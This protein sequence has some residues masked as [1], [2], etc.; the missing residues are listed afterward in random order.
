LSVVA[1]TGVYVEPFKNIG[2]GV[3]VAAADVD[4]DGL[5][6]LVVLQAVSDV[7][8]EV[9]I[10]KVSTAA[11]SGR[12]T[13]DMSGR[14]K[15]CNTAAETSLAAADVDGDGIADIVVL[16]RSGKTSEV[17][18]FSGSGSLIAGFTPADAGSLAA[19]DTNFDGAAEIVAGDAA[20][21][22]NSTFSILDSRGSTSITVSAFKKGHGVRV[23]VGNLGY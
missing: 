2:G 6:E 8:P 3:N 22:G 7:V 12:W 13:A 18:E 16:C 9:K 1:D 21:G 5:P 4:G 11:G 23:S 10:Y 14:F 17:R 15:A 20:S 19:G